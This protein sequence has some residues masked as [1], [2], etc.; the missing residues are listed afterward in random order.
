MARRFL[1]TLSLQEISGSLGDLG[2]FLPLTLGLAVK[3]DLDLGTTLIFTG[4]Y[5]VCTG[6]FFGIPMCVQPMKAIAA[7]AL[8]SHHLTLDQLLL[9]GMFVSSVVLLLGVTKLID[10][11]NSL[12]PK[13]IVHG[14]Q[15][16]VGFKL[17]Q[18]GVSMALQVQGPE[19][20]SSSV[21]RPCLGTDGLL[22]AVFGLLCCLAG[23]WAAFR[24]QEGG[25]AGPSPKQD[26]PPEAKPFLYAPLEDAEAGTRQPCMQARLFQA[27]NKARAPE[28]SGIELLDS[29][30]Q[31]QSLP[32]GQLGCYGCST[33]GAQAPSNSSHICSSHVKELA[34]T[35]HS[36]MEASGSGPAPGRDGLCA[37]TCSTPQNNA[38]TEDDPI[39]CSSGNAIARSHAFVV[40][41]ALIV[42]VVG[43]IITLVSDSGVVSQLRFG[44]S[45]PRL[46]DFTASNLGQG[47]LKAGLAQLPLTTLN[48]VIAVSQLAEQLFPNHQ[49]QARLHPSKVSISVGCMNLVGCWFGAMPCC[50]G[51]GGLAA[52][53]RFGARSGAAPVFL[54]CFKVLFGLLFGSS[55]LPLLSAFPEPLLGAL[56]LFSGI[57][58]ASSCRSLNTARGWTFVLLTATCIN[59]VNDTGIGFAFGAAACAF[60]VSL[61]AAAKRVQGWSVPA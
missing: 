10:T 31:Q 18:H 30:E 44:P 41:A 14:I 6:L 2:T 20:A 27:L 12:I 57:E 58:L 36:D 38:S 9:S 40:P 22:V 50:S 46:L 56:L 4:L 26:P 53:Y 5:N 51:S 47:I 25:G 52:Q 54:G 1:K 19:H 48:S 49:R 45:I 11:V 42:V 15:L 3:C 35:S 55:L 29:V 21:F 60:C 16:G 61:D 37:S 32:P 17:A 8:S 59:A 34:A 33:T 7:V 43:V 24:S 28:H 23:T 39:S 13:S